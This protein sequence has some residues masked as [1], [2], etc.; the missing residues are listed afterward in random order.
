M[1]SLRSG[2]SN[3]LSRLNAMVDSWAT[4]HNDNHVST[5]IFDENIGEDGLSIQSTYD[6]NINNPYHIDSIAPNCE[7][8][9]SPS[10]TDDELKDAYILF[11]KGSNEWWVQLS[12]NKTLLSFDNKWRTFN[13]NI[14]EV[15]AAN[16]NESSIQ[17]VEFADWT[18]KN[19]FARYW[20]CQD[21]CNC[22]VFKVAIGKTMHKAPL[23]VNQ[24]HL[25]VIGTAPQNFEINKFHRNTFLMS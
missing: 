25:F 12:T 18:V 16:V 1:S 21:L 24:R 15:L 22:S 7:I 17:D 4:K 19:K 23:H 6:V 8:L 5:T 9:D 11:M 3:S 20:H 14:A 10:L 13:T 2:I